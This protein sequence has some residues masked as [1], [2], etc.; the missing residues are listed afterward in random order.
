MS[1]LHGWPLAKAYVSDGSAAAYG[2][3]QVFD[4]V[5]PNFPSWELVYQQVDLAT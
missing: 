3:L 2:L 1:N 4:I 5:Q